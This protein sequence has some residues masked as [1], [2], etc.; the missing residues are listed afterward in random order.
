MEFFAGFEPTIQ[1][2]LRDFPQ[3]IWNTTAAI[4]VSPKARQGDTHIS[5]LTFTFPS[6]L[7]I[8]TVCHFKVR[9]RVPQFLTLRNN[10]KWEKREI[11][12]V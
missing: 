8:F 12:K 5:H 4:R 7:K 6:I 1:L 11:I 2:G 10:A 3:L 9:V